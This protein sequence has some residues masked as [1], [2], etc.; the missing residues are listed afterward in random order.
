MLQPHQVEELISLVAVMDRRTLVRQLREY[1]G[2]FP[3][4][5]TGDFLA[6]IPLERLRHIFL[7]LCLQCQQMPEIDEEEIDIPAPHAA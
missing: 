2:N 7:A 5:F 3:I 6:N 1:R 4:D